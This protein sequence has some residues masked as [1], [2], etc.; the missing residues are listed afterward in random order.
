MAP[1]VSCSVSRISAGS[2]G[3]SFGLPGKSDWPF[4]TAASM[5]TWVC[6]SN[7]TEV[8]LSLTQSFIEGIMA[9]VSFIKKNRKGMMCSSFH[10]GEFIMCR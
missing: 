1:G 6:Q 7:G 3:G 9:G 8:I 2:V 4:L 10:P 5:K